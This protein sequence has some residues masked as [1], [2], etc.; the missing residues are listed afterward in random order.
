[1]KR[2]NAYNTSDPAVLLKLK[3]QEARIMLD[4]VRS[5]HP[6]SDPKSLVELVTNRITTQLDVMR[7]LLVTNISA[8]F[9]VE[10]NVNFPPVDISLFDCLFN[11]HVTSKVSDL[12]FEVF[13]NIGAEFVIPLGRHYGEEPVGWFIIADFAES[14]A[15]V[16]NDIVFIE[17][18]GNILLISLENIYL[19]RERV[20]KELIQ[21]ELDVAAKIQKQ[22]LP[23]TVQ[24]HPKLDIHGVNIAHS[25]V[26]G[27]LYDVIQ[28][29]D[30]EFCFCIAD[31]S[32]KGI[33]AALLVATLQANLRALAR[34]GT[35][36]HQMITT[37][38]KIISAITNNEH[39]VTL[40]VAKLNVS[41]RKMAYV[42]AGHNPPF[43]VSDRYVRELTKGC[44]PLGI[45]PIESI[46]IGYERLDRNEMLFMYTD[47]IVEQFN[48]DD[49]MIGIEWTKDFLSKNSFLKAEE[50]AK[51]VIDTVNAHAAETGSNDDMSLLV[52]KVL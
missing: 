34:S 1:M 35:P 36:F 46:E 21:Q 45:L 51:Q 48:P 47:G 42:N 24:L 7:L 9:R 49:E 8:R 15:E 13:E 38:H 3:R 17:T 40:F 28:V 11:I 32:G 6:H 18:V 2:T 12:P 39:F 52:V 20:A 19:F 33:A 14:D 23:D 31:V 16:L 5:I 27:D 26:A 50:I 10:I 29:T 37:L 41:T 4:I 44:I 25:K 22:S 43:V 30:E